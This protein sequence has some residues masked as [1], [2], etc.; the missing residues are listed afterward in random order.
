[1]GVKSSNIE[2]FDRRWNGSEKHFSIMPAPGASQSGDGIAREVRWPT[3]SLGSL[4]GLVDGQF[5]FRIG[6]RKWKCSHLEAAFLSEA[7]HRSLQADPFADELVLEGLEDCVNEFDCIFPLVRGGSLTVTAG[8]CEKCLRIADKLC[9]TELVNTILDFVT[10]SCPVNLETAIPRLQCSRQYSA[11]LPL[12]HII[13]FIASHFHE[14]N[15]EDLETINV[16]HLEMILSEEHLVLRTEDSLLELLC[17]LG[18][19][20]HSL[21]RYV[22][23]EYLTIECLGRCLI[24]I[25]PSDLESR[26]WIPFN[27]FSTTGKSR[28]TETGRETGT[29]CRDEVKGETDEAC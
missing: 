7:A 3:S 4:S 6:G 11:R 20:Y 25:D 28:V 24:S 2:N 1:M 17:H 23:C 29:E 5:T 14:F 26:F 12:H 9:N 27:E 16:Y 13:E 19:D 8:N 15:E 18:S 10:E 22:R 21:L